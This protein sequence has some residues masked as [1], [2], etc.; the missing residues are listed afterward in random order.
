MNGVRVRLVGQRVD[1]VAA[2]N[3]ELRADSMVQQYSSPLRKRSGKMASTR[4]LPTPISSPKV[5]ATAEVAPANHPF[6]PEGSA[7]KEVVRIVRALEDKNNEFSAQ[8]YALV[9]ALHSAYEDIHGGCTAYDAFQVPMTTQMRRLRQEDATLR[10]EL[11]GK[12]REI[13]T[14]RETVSEKD[15][16][17]D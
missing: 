4:R 16:E 5:T 14:L 2:G 9:T 8:S 12:D 7:T 1:S 17:I 3:P 13:E 10:S 6:L 15:G 11:V